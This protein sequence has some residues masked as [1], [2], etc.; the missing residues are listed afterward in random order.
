MRR[1]FSQDLQFGFIL[2][3]AFIMTFLFVRVLSGDQFDINI[4]KDFKPQYEECKSK[5]AVIEKDLEYAM[6]KD[7]AVCECKSD[8]NASYVLFGFVIGCM[9]SIYLIVCG[10]GWLK[11]LKE[12]KKNK[13]DK[14]EK[15]S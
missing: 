10:P 4:T 2:L 9:A 5:M 8:T 3:I 15:K 13:N 12:R 6:S 7:R 1:S 11:I 14:K